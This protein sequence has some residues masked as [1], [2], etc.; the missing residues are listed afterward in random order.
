LKKTLR[1]NP[2]A[3]LVAIVLFFLIAVIVGMW[4]YQVKIMQ[5]HSNPAKPIPTV[6]GVP[7]FQSLV[8]HGE[9]NP[10]N[11]SSV[12]NNTSNQ[13]DK[14]VA[15]HGDS[16]QNQAHTANSYDVGSSSY[17]AASIPNHTLPDLKTVVQSTCGTIA[18]SHYVNCLDGPL[19]SAK[20]LVKGL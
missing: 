18:D 13:P 12:Q 2:D 6:K 17:S 11:S 7:K 19:S 3:G 9:L 10:T 8:L 4:I 15:D 1:E 20:S 5:R 14:P 16:R